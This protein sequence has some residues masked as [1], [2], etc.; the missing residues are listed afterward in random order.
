MDSLLEM[1]PESAKLR[2]ILTSG[3]AMLIDRESLQQLLSA[4]LDSLW[5]CIQSQQFFSDC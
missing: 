2:A 5:V 3:A 4:S 1:R